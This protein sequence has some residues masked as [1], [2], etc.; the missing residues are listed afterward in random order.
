MGKVIYGINWGLRTFDP[1]K[2][3]EDEVIPEPKEKPQ[4]PAAPKPEEPKKKAAVF[5]VMPDEPMPEGYP[6]YRPLLQRD[7]LILWAWEI[8]D[9]RTRIIWLLSN[10]T[11]RK[12]E[13][14]INDEIDNELLS[15][16]CPEEKYGIY[17]RWGRN[18]IP[19]Y[20]FYT[21]PPELSVN[22]RTAFIKRLKTV[23]VSSNFD[24][25]YSLGRQRQEEEKAVADKINNYKFITA[26][27]AEF[28]KIYRQLND[29][30]KQKAREYM[31]ILLQEQNGGKY[32]IDEKR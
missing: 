30:D 8:Y 9:D 16:V 32:G 5:E 26:E 19:D 20:I 13:T 22:T 15:T 14:T 23:G 3:D 10:R 24:Y 6:D 2:P 11:M 31:E 21:A 28:L 7:G 29:E 17:D 18:S 25:E 12:Y 1:R 4:E 27:E